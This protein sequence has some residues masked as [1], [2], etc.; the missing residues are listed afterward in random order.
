MF[1]TESTESLEE[2]LGWL[3]E[4]RVSDDWF[5]DDGGHFVLVGF[6]DGLDGLKVVVFSAV[7]C[8]SCGSWNS[9]RVWQSKCGNTGT[10]LYQERVSVSVVASFEFDNLFTSGESTNK[11][12]HSH[13]GFSSRVCESNHFHGW[14]SSNNSLGQFIF[15]W[16]RST[17][18]GS[19]FHGCLDSVQYIIISMSQNG[20]SP[21][22]NVI[23]V[24]VL[25]NIPGVSTLYPVEDNR[26]SSDTLESTYR[27]R[28][29]SRHQGLC[30]SKDLFTLCERVH[31]FFH[32]TLKGGSVSWASSK[33]NW[34][35]SS[36]RTGQESGSKSELHD[37][38][39][40]LGWVESRIF[41][42]NEKI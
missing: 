42:S 4:S 41:F 6:E 23:D 3:D 12:D 10:G 26:V 17:E 24:L 16:A 40:N 27:R 34:C 14:H 18:G 32:S 20:R 31:T 37:V 29:T 25:V 7:S 28:H 15:Q 1:V 8:R 21:G 39:E 35:K 22:S 2:F 30:F 19:L 33:R 38:D 9:R 5:K 13:A 11:T 36:G